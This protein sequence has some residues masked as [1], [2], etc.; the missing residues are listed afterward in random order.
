MACGGG[1]AAFLHEH[2]SAHQFRKAL[3]R[4]G[5]YDADSTFHMHGLFQAYIRL[6]RA[7][8]T[9]AEFLSAL[10]RHFGTSA[11]MWAV[12]ACEAERDLCGVPVDYIFRSAILPSTRGA[13]LFLLRALDPDCFTVLP[14]RI[15]LQKDFES[16]DCTIS[17]ALGAIL[18][19]HRLSTKRANV[20]TEYLDR[21]APAFEDRIALE[22]W[23]SVPTTMKALIDKHHFIE[24]LDRTA[25]ELLL[26]M[27]PTVHLLELL[28]VHQPYALLHYTAPDGRLA[29]ARGRVRIRVAKVLERFLEPTADMCRALRDLAT[30][31]SYV[32]L[33][34]RL[35]DST[36]G[37][38]SEHMPP[39]MSMAKRA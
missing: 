15:M 39:P 7:K 36:E 14:D 9:I 6:R 33:Y 21:L 12:C 26:D 32:E 19:E 24:V 23:L 30:R 20:M 22:E 38:V 11:E 31:L 8:M 10:V 16:L 18:E 34:E 3:R 4:S 27:E 29:V 1:Y 25:P 5:A 37:H 28:I 35:W 13:T 17:K 2:G